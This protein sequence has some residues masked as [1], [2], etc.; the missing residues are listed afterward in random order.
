M[1]FRKSFVMDA[2]LENQSLTL[3]AMLDGQM[4][5]K[6]SVT[7]VFESTL[8]PG[9]P[10][11]AGKSERNPT[12]VIIL[13]LDAITGSSVSL[14]SLSTS[15]MRCSPVRAMSV[16]SAISHADLVAGWL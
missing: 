4:V 15:T 14:A 5:I 12:N 11:I 3:V 8:E 7:N 2:E 10:R 13:T 1:L 6:T 16:Q 9:L